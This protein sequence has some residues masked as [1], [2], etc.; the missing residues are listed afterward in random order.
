MKIQEGLIYKCADTF[1]V[2]EILKV[3]AYGLRVFD[4]KL[5]YV[6]FIGNES[7]L[8]LPINEDVL[9]GFGFQKVPAYKVNEFEWYERYQIRNAVEGRTFEV[10]II[11]SNY[12][13]KEHTDIC[14]AVGG[15]RQS[16]KN[17]NHAH[18]L[19]L[20]YNLITGN[21]LKFNIKKV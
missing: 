20:A 12:G 21:D 10:Q 13:N 14:Y 19:Q 18:D 15:D 11:H 8:P 7:I 16:I 1:R 4:F 2:L 5:D 3:S 17:T 6:T 9:L